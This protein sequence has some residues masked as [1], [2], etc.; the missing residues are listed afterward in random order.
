MRSK[1]SIAVFGLAA[2]ALALPAAAQMSMSSA[3]V[4]GS[5]GQSKFKADCGSFSCDK[6]DT[7]FRLFGGY[8]FTRNIAAELGYADL[9]KLKISGGGLSGEIEATAWDLSGVFSW[10]F[11]NQFAVFGRLGVART[12]GKV[13]GAFGSAKDNK[14]GVTWGLGAQYD[15]NRNLGLR[16]E[17]QRYRVDAGSAGTGDVDNL[18]IGVLYRFQ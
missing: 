13:S 8:Q 11:A 1:A 2:A 4:G 17:W 18:N 15:F 5:I 3:Y 12:E 7:S 10:P 14:S 16:G 6:N 9:G